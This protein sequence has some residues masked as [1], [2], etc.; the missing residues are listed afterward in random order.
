MY[1]GN[2]HVSMYLYSRDNSIYSMVV[3]L[4]QKLADTRIILAGNIACCFNANRPWFIEGTAIIICELAVILDQL[5]IDLSQIMVLDKYI[6]V[7]LY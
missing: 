5:I 6:C 2:W 4:I 1:V 3:S 7:I